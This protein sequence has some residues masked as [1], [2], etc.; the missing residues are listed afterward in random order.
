MPIYVND[1]DN[2]LMLHFGH[3]DIEIAHAWDAENQTPELAFLAIEAKPIG[4]VN[5]GPPRL[6]TYVPVA[7][8]MHFDKVE[9]LDVLI[10][11]AT[12]LRAKFTP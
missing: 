8:R 11:R 9:S 2:A 12:A 10:E 1:S 6:S 5:D 7:V 4:A 3:G